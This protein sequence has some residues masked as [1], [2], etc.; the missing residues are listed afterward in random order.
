M[1]ANRVNGRR[2]PRGKLAAIALVVVGAVV[3][4][5]ATVLGLHWATAPSPKAPA[6]ARTQGLGF[7]KLDRQAP[8]VLLPSLLGSG[9]VSVARLAGKPIV[10][11]FWASTCEVCKSETPALA[12]VA[13]ALGD[14]VTFV[15]IDSVDRQ[16]PATAFITK[17]HVPYPIGFDPDGTAAIK[18]GV[19]ALPVT[20]FLSPSG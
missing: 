11:N 18:Y 20:F 15:G 10:L 12:S 3:L 6:M 14:K 2:S 9:T 17:Y 4:S 19:V 8:A 13:R 7:T 1:F 5:T 16:G